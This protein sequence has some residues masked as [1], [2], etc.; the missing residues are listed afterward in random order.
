MLIKALGNN[1]LAFL[2]KHFLPY[3]VK[4]APVEE[5]GVTLVLDEGV[6]RQADRP[7]LWK[8]CLYLN[9]SS[10]YINF[11]YSITG[12]FTVTVWFKTVALPSSGAYTL[13][14]STNYSI[15]GQIHSD[16]Y[17]YLDCGGNAIW[18]RFSS[19]DIKLGEWNAITFRYDTSETLFVDAARVFLNKEELISVSTSGTHT[20]STVTSIDVG[21]RTDGNTNY[22]LGHIKQFAVTNT[23]L[24]EAQCLNHEAFGTEYLFEEGDGTTVYATDGTEGTITTSNINAV[25]VEQED[26][27]LLPESGDYVGYQ[28]SLYKFNANSETGYSYIDTGDNTTLNGTGNFTITFR[29]KVTQTYQGFSCFIDKNNSNGLEILYKIADQSIRMWWNGTRVLNDVVVGAGSILR[30]YTFRRVGNNLEFEVDGTIITTV[31]VTG[32]SIGTTQNWIFGSQ[33]HTIEYYQFKG[34]MGSVLMYNSNVSHSDILSRT[35]TPTS[36]WTP[37]GDR[38]IDLQTNNVATFGNGGLNGGV[39]Y[40]PLS[41][42][43]K[44][45]ITTYTGRKDFPITP[46][47]EPC[48]R[49]NAG[50]YATFNG[51][52]LIAEEEYIIEALQLNYTNAST[53]TYL[54][55]TLNDNFI[56][57]LNSSNWAFRLGSAYV[58]P[59][60]GLD[61]VALSD[62]VV[63]FRIY[64]MTGSGSTLGNAD[65]DFTITDLNGNI[66]AT[67]T[68]T[69]VALSGTLL[70][71]MFASLTSA[72][73]RAATG[74][75]PWVKFYVDNT[76][77]YQ[78]EYLGS[79]SL[80]LWERKNGNHGTVT[81]SNIA[82][83]QGTQDVYSSRLKDGWNETSELNSSTL[84]TS[85]SVLGSGN[86]SVEDTLG[87]VLFELS[88]FD[89]TTVSYTNNDFEFVRDVDG[90]YNNI[91]IFTFDDGIRLTSDLNNIPVGAKIKLTVD[92][93]MGSY[94]RWYVSDGT[95]QVGSYQFSGGEVTIEWDKID[96]GNNGIQLRMRTDSGYV[97]AGASP[98]KIHSYS[99]SVEER[100]PASLTTP[101]Q[102]VLGNLLTYTGGKLQGDLKVSLPQYKQG[103]TFLQ[104][105][106]DLARELNGVKDRLLTS[107]SLGHSDIFSCFKGT[108]TDYFIPDETIQPS[109]GEK[110]EFGLLVTNFPINADQGIVGSYTN[111]NRFIIFESVAGRILFKWAGDFIRFETG[112]DFTVINQFTI[113]VGYT[114]TDAT[115]ITDCFVKVYDLNGT[116]LYNSTVASTTV[117]STSITYD[118]IFTGEPTG[119]RAQFEAPYIWRKID[120]SFTNFWIYTEDEPYALI[121]I[122]GT[123]GAALTTADVTANKGYQSIYNPYINGFNTDSVVKDSASWSAG[124]IVGS[125]REHYLEGELWYYDGNHSGGGF[126]NWSA[127]YENGYLNLK[128]DHV[129]TGGETFYL[130]RNNVSSSYFRPGIRYRVT[131]TFYMPTGSNWN[132]VYIT[133]DSDW[134]DSLGHNTLFFPNASEQTMVLEFVPSDNLAQNDIQIRV[135]AS[136]G[137][138]PTVD[139]AVEIRNFKLEAMDKVIAQYPYNGLDVFGNELTTPRTKAVTKALKYTDND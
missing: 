25:R 126:P 102:D 129:T 76:L 29:A 90:L 50:D 51:Y 69:A 89:N 10:D 39:E 60:T 59:S 5:N 68:E 24:T 48:W 87:N 56:I 88:A 92:V 1:I 65:V 111:T 30:R 66:L 58:S 131:V 125:S 16:G 130:F 82:D 54:G 36:E 122:L 33:L 128:P 95:T 40:Y 133:G 8:R 27:P 117:G 53:G 104:S 26:A 6:D 11:D 52:Q 34:E 35:T 22:F 37:L 80:V 123:N 134:I 72:P 63:K 41:V 45:L 12:D 46:K 38:W 61:L 109:T 116:E 17:I 97:A 124:S 2:K 113:Q 20:A 71:M 49:T 42:M 3:L 9:G 64:N 47:D 74:D 7:Y 121:D 136:T 79:N 78:W 86:D 137:F 93:S 19:S 23:A 118:A 107:I 73:T 43:G 13:F 70:D 83:N 98:F 115:T 105:N 85:G 135:L 114:R 57:G 106:E 18:T 21:R 67:H 32:K 91:F 62:F 99:I 31:D 84:F 108:S 139:S 119:R 138:D 110:I 15:R 103:T 81:A 112:L 77:N 55:Y 101:T 44:E 100:V 28:Q 120:D 127:T 96:D 14:Q 75:I 4:Q 94:E 132:R